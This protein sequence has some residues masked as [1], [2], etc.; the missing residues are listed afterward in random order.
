MLFIVVSMCTVYVFSVYGS[1][2]KVLDP[3]AVRCSVLRTKLGSSRRAAIA[4][5]HGIISVATL[6]IPLDYIY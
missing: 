4:L 2:T 5:N 1:Q 3:L 6:K